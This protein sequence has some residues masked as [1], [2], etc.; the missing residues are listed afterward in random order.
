MNE[1]TTPAPPSPTQ[2]PQG[3]YVPG[4]W[5]PA[6]PQ[7]PKSS[8]YRVASGI[9]AVALGGFLLL[10]S[11]VLAYQAFTYGLVGGVLVAVLTIAA[12]LGN[13]ISG[14]VLLVQ[15]RSRRGS[16]PKAV[17]AFAA[18]PLLPALI[19]II[20]EVGAPILSVVSVVLAVPL[21]VVMGIGLAKEKRGA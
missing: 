13:L 16:A 6:G 2:P 1:S 21:F 17:L 4:H 11:S 5:V 15:H 18:L 10:I 7:L 12:G 19:S 20:G 9:L 8:G 3:Q 14:I